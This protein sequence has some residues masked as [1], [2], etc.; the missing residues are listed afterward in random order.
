MIPIEANQSLVGRMA[1]R[2]LRRAHVGRFQHR[3]KA[4]ELIGAL[5]DIE[6]A[7]AE[8]EKAERIAKIGL[9]NTE[10]RKAT[11]PALAASGVITSRLTARGPAFVVSVLSA[12]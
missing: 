5:F 7:I 1:A 11:P 4:R 10:L 12:L 3:A 2:L 9:F 8:L 6:R